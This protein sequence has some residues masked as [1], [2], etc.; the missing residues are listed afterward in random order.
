MR[1]RRRKRKECREKEIEDGEWRDVRREKQ[2]E[3]QE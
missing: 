1:R 3:I 2:E